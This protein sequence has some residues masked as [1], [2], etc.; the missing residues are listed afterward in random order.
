M[1]YEFVTRHRDSIITRTRLRLTERPWP[2]PSPSELDTGV[3]LF[4]DQ[5]AETLQLEATRA[6]V[7]GNVIGDAAAV[8]GRRWQAQ[9]FTIAQVVHGYGD[10]CQAVAEVALEQHEA[11][12][13]EEFHTLNRCL[14]T[15]IAEAVT[16]H[17]RATSEQR[18][19]EETERI[20]GVSHEIRNFVNTAIL[21][22]HVL[23]SGSVA[24]NGQTGAVLGQTLLRLRAFVGSTLS[25]VR[26]AADRQRR[27]RLP[28]QTFLNDVVGTARLHAEYR[29]LT[30]TA[31]SVSSE[32]MMTVDPELLASAVNNLLTNA[33]KYSR[34]H[35]RVS[36]RVEQR[37]HHLVLAV[38]DEC[39]GIPPHVGDPFEPFGERR[40]N[41]RTGLGLGLSIARKAVRAH[42]GDIRI[43]NLPGVG[44]I[45]TIEIPLE[46]A[47]N[48]VG[49]LATVHC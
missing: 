27:E 23:K 12:S 38:Q 25:E 3:P 35:G 44:C 47:A 8:Q 10:I 21:A 39:G 11:M 14:D 7:A 34:P 30:F 41:D 33:F 22:F 29:G 16:E 45:F 49:E 26:L 18:D 42:G 1:L 36:L 19:A 4:L 28:V 46:P 15:A 2:S 20:G 32:L 5:L 48:A 17:A 40:G 43:D 9:G 13:V 24:I 37:G 31:D 6:P